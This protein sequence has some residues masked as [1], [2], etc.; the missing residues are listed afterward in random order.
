MK[1]SLVNKILLGIEII[2]VFLLLLLSFLMFMKASTVFFLFLLF[3][4]LSM[5]SLIYLLIKTILG[6]TKN[7][8]TRFV[9]LSHIGVLITIVGFI[10]ILIDPSPENSFFYLAFGVVAF[11]PYFH[12][13]IVNNFFRTESKITH[14]I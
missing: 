11:I 4:I 5:V 9:Y 3:S 1:V 7:L 13:M 6:S 12:V 14:E 8:R 2:P 10:S